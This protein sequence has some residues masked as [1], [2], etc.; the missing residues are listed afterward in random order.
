M[1]T[2]PINAAYLGLWALLAD[3]SPPKGQ[4]DGAGYTLPQPWDNKKEGEGKQRE[5]DT[6][7]GKIS[8]VQRITTKWVQLVTKRV[9]KVFVA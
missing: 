9:A 4:S 3:R 1:L 7:A 5:E 6:V 8:L 2:P